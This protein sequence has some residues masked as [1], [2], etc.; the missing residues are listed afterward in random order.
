VVRNII[1]RPWWEIRQRFFY[2]RNQR[3]MWFYWDRN[4]LQ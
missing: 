1:R 2:T 3:R 4:Q